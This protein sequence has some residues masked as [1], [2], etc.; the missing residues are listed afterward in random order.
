M[1]GKQTFGLKRI[2]SLA[3]AAGGELEAAARGINGIGRG[4]KRP[5]LLGL[6]AICA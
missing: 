5:S 4:A 2:A 3:N 1:S 6:G